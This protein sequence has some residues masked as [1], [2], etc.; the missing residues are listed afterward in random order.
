[1]RKYEVNTRHK[2]MRY[3]YYKLAYSSAISNMSERLSLTPISV[4]MS[5][6][7]TTTTS[8]SS[9]SSKSSSGTNTTLKTF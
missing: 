6:H 4:L 9:S 3:F 2:N 7:S 8:S 5:P 1:M